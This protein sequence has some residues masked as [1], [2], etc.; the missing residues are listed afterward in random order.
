[1][2]I[3][4]RLARHYLWLLGRGV[5]PTLRLEPPARFSQIARI[6]KRHRI[7]LPTHVKA[8]LKKVS[9]AVA[10]GWPLSAVDPVPDEWP[11]LGDPDLRL[12]LEVIDEA[13]A[14]W[15]A[16][17]SHSRMSGTTGTPLK[18]C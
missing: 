11:L 16:T 10:Y 9:G 5:T 7:R 12:G 17:E 8:F 3:H 2:S 18:G 1:M 15:R 4:E 13:I 14:T 6:E